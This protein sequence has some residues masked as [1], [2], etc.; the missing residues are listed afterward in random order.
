MQKLA[1][2]LMALRATAFVT[3]NVVGAATDGAILCIPRI[4]GEHD[5][6]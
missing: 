2:I 5:Q 4:G 3:R 1:L 6:T